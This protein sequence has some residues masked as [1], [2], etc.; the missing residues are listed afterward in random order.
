MNRALILCCFV[1]TF[2]AAAFAQD[3]VDYVR[4]VKPIFAK[5]CVDCHGPKKQKAGLRLDAA[6]AIAKGLERGP[7]IVPGKADDSLIVHA[8]AGVKEVSLMPPEGRERLTATEIAT[9]K[10]WI[11]AGAPAPKEEAITTAKNDHWAFQPLKR[12]AAP[13]VKNAA[14]VRNAIDSY[15]LARLEKENLTPS[16]DADRITL[17]RRVSLDLT[18]L[19]PSP[20]EVEAFLAD[21]SPNAYD[22][23]V[24]RLLKSPHY[25]ERWARHWLDVARYADSSGFTIDGP[26]TIW[27]YRDWVIQSLNKD[28]PVDQFIVEQI[29]GD[30][31]PNATVAQ[32]VATGF[33]R[34]TLFNQEGGIDLE[35][36]RVEYIIDRVNTTGAAFLGLTVGCAQCHDHKYDPITQGEFYRMFAF[37]NNC[38]EPNMPVLSVKEQKQL[39]AFK[40]R[41]AELLASIKAF[42][43]MSPDQQK[44]W[45][46]KLTPLQI[47]KLTEDAPRLR[48]LLDKPDYQRTR[49]EAE[50]L[51]ILVRQL[52]Q[53]PQFLASLGDAFP[54]GLGSAGSVA[55]HLRIVQHRQ[56]VETEL[57][58]IKRKKPDSATTLVMA[59]RKTPRDTWFLIKGDFT[60]KG[61]KMEPGT[62]ASLHPLKA[63]PNP[64]RLDFA[65]WLA[66]P[67][68]PLTPRVFVNRV[69]Q[70]YFGLGIVETENDFGLQGTPPS[71]PE[72]L[73]Y[74]A[75]ELIARKWSLKELHRQIVTSSTYRQDSLIR[76]ELTK[77]DPRNRLLG[78]QNRLRLEAEVVRDVALSASGLLN[79]KIGGPSVFPPQPDGVFAF[80]QTQRN[81]KA[82]TGGDRYRRG[83]YT[84][85]WRSAP[86][87][88][89]MAFDAPDSNT[90]CT[91]R[92]R[93]NTPLQ[94]LTLLNDRAFVEF[95]EALA[96][97]VNR[98]ATGADAD[99]LRHAFRLCLARE[100]KTAELARLQVLLSSLDGQPDAWPQ[101]CRVL[102]NLDE[103]ITRE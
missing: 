90:T 87:P 32:K 69:W 22:K 53:V 101:V 44:K 47:A 33:H 37:L 97:R 91:R 30:M 86:H 57:Q 61:P 23:V 55:A 43:R 21:T 16:K 89:L 2:S 66:D 60:R 20:A 49:E 6:T 5:H 75:S 74:L 40:T 34:N 64:N 48:I 93:S 12:T 62:P 26:R 29:A 80:T 31:L 4:D 85:F 76:P 100:P 52:D 8:L 15:I 94:A 10:R 35:M 88:G 25:G 59:E 1:P 54:G 67:A 42:D 73:D 71:H 72:L 19:P 83:L 3:P 17:L 13:A 38:D 9:I 65:R 84:Y 24:D 50:E 7:A 14:W 70:A 92:T 95:A 79:P 63:G 41:E 99:K 39:A 68:N 56:D 82:E 18:G 81:W 102:L 51:H 28:Q 27:P 98:E 103:F 96:K 45:E 77:A 78:R 46:A 58:Q 36:F 11:N